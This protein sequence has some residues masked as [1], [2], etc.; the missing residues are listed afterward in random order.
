MGSKVSKDLVLAEKSVI[1]GLI[2][3]LWPVKGLSLL[4]MANSGQNTNGSQFFKQQPHLHGKYFML[5]KA[6]FFAK[7][8]TK[9]LAHK[10]GLVAISFAKVIVSSIKPS[11]EIVGRI[12]GTDLFCNTLQYPV[13]I[14]I[15]GFL[16]ARINSGTLCFAN[17]SFI[18]ERIMRSV[19]EECNLEEITKGRLYVLVLDMSNVTNIDSSGIHALEELRHNL[20]AQDIELVVV[21]PRWQ[22]ITKMKAAKLIDKIGGNRIFLSIGDAVDAL[23]DPKIN[24]L[25]GC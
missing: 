17:A 19:K 16:I 23:I 7:E 3:W 21:N 14:K 15:P 8:Y 25:D 18:R 4:S 12:P 2:F 20:T 24:G 5:G 10:I 22:V 13:A 11:I 6:N 9:L 1:N